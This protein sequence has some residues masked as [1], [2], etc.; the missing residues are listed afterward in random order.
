MVKI[1]IFFFCRNL[2]GIIINY[3]IAKRRENPDFQINLASALRQAETSARNY[4]LFISGQ[5]TIPG[6]ILQYSLHHQQGA[7]A[8]KDTSFHLLSN[9]AYTGKMIISLNEHVIRIEVLDRHGKKCAIEE[10]LRD[11]EQSIPPLLDRLTTYGKDRNVQLL[12]LI[13]LSLLNARGAHE[14]KKVFETL[15]ERY[16]ECMEYDR[17]MI[18]YDLDSLIGVNKSESDSNMGTSYS[19]SI[20]NQGVYV[21]IKSRFQE[22]QVDHLSVRDQQREKWAIAVV[23]EDFLLKKFSS[24]VQFPRTRQQQKED[25]EE[26]RRSNNELKCVKCQ[27]NYVESDNKIDAC[28]FHDGFVYDNYTPDLA[29]WK[30]SLA[31]RQLLQEDY[32]STIGEDDEPESEEKDKTLD[33]NDDDGEKS[34]MVARKKEL[35]DHKKTRF[36]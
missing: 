9:I 1:F 3:H 15:K 23:H 32:N 18:V 16:D 17:S 10:K 5:S 6:L 29:M 36:R 34:N 24:D 31:Q 35:E 27:A 20:V 7:K 11:N 21:Q 12:Q 30:P 25:D 28:T 4:Q 26:Y 8:S 19:S 14:E 33:S 2:N 22:A 13:D